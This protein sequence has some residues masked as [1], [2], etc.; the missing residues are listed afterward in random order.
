[1]IIYKPNFLSFLY[2]RISLQT[3]AS[4][5]PD[6]IHTWKTISRLFCEHC[7]DEFAYDDDGDDDDVR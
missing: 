2:S 3:G 7:I 1:M 4:R 5:R 6:M